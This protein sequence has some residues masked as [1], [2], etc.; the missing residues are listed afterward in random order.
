LLLMPPE[1]GLLDPIA[2]LTESLKMS[3]WQT[4]AQK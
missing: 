4:I 2:L 3:N 1:S